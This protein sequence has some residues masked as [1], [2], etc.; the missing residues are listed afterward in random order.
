MKTKAMIKRVGVLVLSAWV[1]TS[2][3]S[4][5]GADGRGYG[6]G[7]RWASQDAAR[8]DDGHIYRHHDGRRSAARGPVDLRQARRQA[9]IHQGLRSGRL[10]RAEAHAL[11]H[12]QG[13]IRRL[14][15]HLRSDGILS[16]AERRIL[17]RRL[18]AASRHIYRDRHDEQWRQARAEPRPWGREGERSRW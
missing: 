17:D 8:P 9:R 12:E 1:L 3:S 4:W 15:H 7:P 14:E 5:A 16:Q 13:H 18:D 6:D 10:T 2:G 11:M